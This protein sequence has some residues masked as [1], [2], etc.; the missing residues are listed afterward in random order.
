MLVSRDLQAWI[1][2]TNLKPDWLR[3]GTDIIDDSP[4]PTFNMTFSLSGN[5]VPNAGIP[6]QAN[7]RGKTVSALAS[8][9]GNIDAAAAF[10]F[11]GV[12]ALLEGIGQFCGL[13]GLSI[14]SL[15][16]R[17]PNPGGRGLDFSDRHGAQRQT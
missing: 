16:T 7:C 2:N 13:W 5:T 4:A 12:A 1:R 9:F 17:R 3:I 15:P 8:Q 14:H 11:S 6:G 10:G